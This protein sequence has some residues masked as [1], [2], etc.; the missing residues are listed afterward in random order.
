MRTD[1]YC[2]NCE[3][4]EA[5]EPHSCPYKEAA[6]VGQD[7]ADEQCNCCDACYLECKERR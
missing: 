3:E 6:F 4:G 2:D 5:T 7:C 1:N